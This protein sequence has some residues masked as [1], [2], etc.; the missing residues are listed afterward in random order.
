VKD[1]EFIRSLQSWNKAAERLFGYS[2]A[3]TIGHSIMM[4]IPPDRIDEEPK[5]LERLRRGERIDHF[6]TKRRTKKGT[7]FSISLTVSPIR[8]SEG[9]I[10]GASKVAR[11]ITRW[12][13]LEEM[14]VEINATLRR[15]NEDLQH[16][17]YSG[18][19]DL[20]EPLPHGRVL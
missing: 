11:D 14:L 4:L 17:P 10:A 3:E 7:I 19:H 2:A 16:F 6:E 8:N 12:V 13:Q 9:V 18:S 20:Q 5:I 15:S 1:F